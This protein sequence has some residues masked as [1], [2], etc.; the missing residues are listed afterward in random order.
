MIQRESGLTIAIPNWNHRPYLPR[1]INSAIATSR[2]VTQ[3]TGQPVEILVLDD[4][5]RDGSQRFLNDLATSGLAD[6]LVTHFSATNNGLGATRN[7]AIK[8]AR[9]R[10]VLFLDADN[11]L[12]PDG[13]A[14]LFSAA[15]QTG[16]AFTYGTLIDVRL[17]RAFNVRSNERASTRLTVENYIDALG[18]VD[19]EVLEVYGGYREDRDLKQWE[20]WDLLLHLIAENLEIVFVPLVVAEYHILRHSMLQEASRATPQD[21]Y[22]KLAR[23][24]F[25]AGTMEW[26]FRPIGRVFHPAIGLIDEDWSDDQ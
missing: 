6:E 3:Q 14:S 10:W 8:L 25:Q 26:D 9:F 23:Q 16:A 4:A 20:D 2:R 11:E 13:A 5:S 1:S 18:I 12:I 19:T 22:R 21:D 7:L 15:Q 17:G 24:Y